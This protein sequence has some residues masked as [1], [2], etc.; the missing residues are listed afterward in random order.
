MPPAVWERVSE[1]L[2]LSSVVK[3]FRLES[4][5]HLLISSLSNLGGRLAK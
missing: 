3:L 1:L 4:P 5:G 2:D